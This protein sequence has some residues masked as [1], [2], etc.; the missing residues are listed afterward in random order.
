MSYLVSLSIFPTDKGESV[1]QYVSKVVKL[2]KESGHPYRLTPMATIVEVEDIREV[3]NLM[4]KAYKI[5]QEE[6]C[7]RIYTV[8]TVDYRKGKSN[9]IEQKVKSVEAKIGEVNKL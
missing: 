7:N 5:L 2:V 1:S 8:M 6:G 9:R 4:E 3:F